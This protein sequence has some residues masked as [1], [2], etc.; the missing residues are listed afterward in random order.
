MAWQNKTVLNL[1]FFYSVCSKEKS[2]KYPTIVEKFGYF[3]RK[4]TTGKAS[5]ILQLLY[6][7]T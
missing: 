6:I 2:I 1:L 4:S 7:S 3:P 5:M